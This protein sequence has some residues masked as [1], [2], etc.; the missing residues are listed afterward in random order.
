MAKIKINELAVQV[1]K[2][3]S[4]V[5]SVLEELG[6]ENNGKRFVSTSS[7]DEKIAQRVK[8]RLGVKIEKPQEPSIKK[9]E[10]MAEERKPKQA[11]SSKTDVAKKGRA[12]EAGAQDAP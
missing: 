11:D 5:I 8:E 9:E 3:S 10:R 2:K 1:N 7:I 6:E 4:E 12:A